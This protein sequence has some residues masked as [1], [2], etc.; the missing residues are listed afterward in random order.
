MLK[1]WK[2]RK[3]F[4]CDLFRH[5][6]DKVEQEALGLDPWAPFADEDEWG[7]VKWLIAR[8]RHMKTSFSSKYMLMK[9]I[10]KLPHGTEWEL[11]SIHVKGNLNGTNGQPECKD[12]ELWLW[13]PVDCICELMANLE[14]D[15]KVS[16]SPEKV[17]ADAEGTIRQY[18]EMWAGEWWWEMQQRLPD[19]AVVVPV[20][21]ASDKTS[22][23]QFCGDQ[24]V[25]PVYLILSNISKDVH[26]QPSEHAAILLECFSQDTRSLERYRLFHYCMSQVLEPL[27]SAGNNGIEITCPDRQV[28]RMH[29]IIAA[30]IADFPE[31]CLVT[32]CMENRCP[33]CRGEMRNLAMC[34]QDSALENLHLHSRSEMSNEQFKGELGLQAIYSPSWATLPHNDIFLCITPN[35]LH[36]LH[37]GV[38]KDHLISWCSNIIGKEELDTCFKAMASYSGLRHFKKGISKQKQWMG[39]D[40]RELQCVNNQVV[41]AYQTHT[42][43]TL[44]F[45]QDALTS[46][47]ANKNCTTQS[48]LT[49]LKSIPCFTTSNAICLFG[50]ADGFNTKLP[51]RLHIDF[52]KC[53]YHASN[54]HDYVVQMTTWLHRQESIAIQDAYLWWWASQHLDPVNNSE[55]D[56]S[57][58]STSVSNLDA[59]QGYFVPRRCPFPNSTIQQLLHDYGTTLFIPALEDFLGKHMPNGSQRKLTPHDRVDVYKY[60]KVLS[61][62]QPHV[63]TAPVIPS[64]DAR[65]GP[66][67]AHFDTVL[68]I[69]DEDQYTGEGISGLRVGEVKVIFELPSCFRHFPRPLAYIHWF[70]PLQTFNDNLQSFKLMRSSLAA[71]T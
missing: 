70:Q 60:L 37:K 46:F 21:L 30:Y 45:M 57:D 22:L 18:D 36:Q 53:A 2:M 51:E 59:S 6:L 1:K 24:E 29:P 42:D 38:F 47:H 3:E 44:A 49:Y 33:K 48:T 14:F 8:M 35:I 55:L 15:G 43:T 13:N 52:T 62:A 67:P 68:V 26:H 25:W 11:K 19:G 28:R 9:A 63:C 23:S 50:S 20:I 65:K 54:C 71:G 32:C 31:Q 16:Y 39:A 5:T 41:A 12:L 66:A 4:G 64:K 17:F 34:D 40:Y 61:P 10:N 7:L 56:N 27:I 58:G 69:E